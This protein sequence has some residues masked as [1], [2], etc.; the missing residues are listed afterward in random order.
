MS[1]HRA[2]VSG[3]GHEHDRAAQVV[4]GLRELQ[5]VEIGERDD[6]PDVVQ[7]DEVARGHPRTGVVDPGHE[8]PAV[9]VVESRRELVDVGGDRRRAGAAE[10]R[11][12]VDALARAREQDGRHDCGA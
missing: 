5:V 8:R 1:E 2:I 12:D 11:D 6:Q 9:G 4:A 3:F 10:G 7:L